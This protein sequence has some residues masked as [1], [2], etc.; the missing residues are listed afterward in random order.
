MTTQPPTTSNK[1]IEN[2]LAR[3]IAELQNRLASLEDALRLNAIEDRVADLEEDD[4]PGGA[5]D[6]I[7]EGEGQ[8][9]LRLALATFLNNEN[10]ARAT[11]DVIAALGS[12]IKGWSALK[13]KE[14]H[15]QKVISLGTCF[16]GLGFSA[17][18]LVVLSSLLWHDKITKELAA[19]LLGSLLGYWYG[20]DKP[21]S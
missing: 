15:S 9:S 11:S 4:Q 5:A 6:S 19:G 1:S 8:R 10:I 21:R 14:L 12:T 13:A 16:A 17:F 2:E 20:R 7:G 3:R 18:L